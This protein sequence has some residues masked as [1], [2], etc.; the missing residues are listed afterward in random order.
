MLDAV[1]LR[2]PQ[3]TSLFNLFYTV[4]G[5]CFYA[6]GEVV[7]LIWSAEGARMG[8]PL[9]SFGFDLALQGPLLRCAAK[10]PNVVVRSLTD[11]CNLALLLPADRNEAKVAVLELRAALA[12]LETDAKDSLNLDLNMSKC[13]L[14]L[15]PDHSLMEEDLECFEGMKR[16][17]DGMR[18]AG[19]PIDDDAYCA[20]FVGQNVNAA[21][22]KC[23]LAWHPPSGG[24]A[25]AAQVLR[26]SAKLPITGR[27][28]ISNS[29]ALCAL[30]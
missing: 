8:C 16:P 14:L 13:A 6:I 29:T 1:Q 22:A 20:Q 18:V 2:C 19:A 30:R 3:L 28:P 15:P 17:A 10:T 21:L 23:R 26:A 4:D 24:H 12:Q 11:D 27:A 9:G 5:A 7:E 25:A